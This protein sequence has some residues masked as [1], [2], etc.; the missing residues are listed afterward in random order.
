MDF[1]LKLNGIREHNVWDDVDKAYESDRGRIINSAAIR[2]LQQKTQ[3]FPLERNSAVRSR[4]THSLEVQQVGRF[5][6]RTIF[7][8]YSKLSS[9][10]QHL[11]GLGSFERKLETLVE[12]ACLMHDIGNPPFGHFGEGALTEWFT[13]HIEELCELSQSDLT[14]ELILDVSHFEG[15]AQG[16]RLISSLLDLNLTYSQA[17]GILKY[18]RCG[19]SKK[20]NKAAE[21]YYVKKK[22]GYYFSEKK[23]VED[24]CAK[25]RTRIGNR[26]LVSYI[27]EAA[28]DISYCIADLEDA[29]E[30]SILDQVQ[31]SKLIKDA[32]ENNLINENSNEELR[33]SERNDEIAEI[34]KKLEGLENKAKGD[35]ASF[36][37]QFRVAL[38]HPLVEHAATR[39]IENI[40][41]VYDGELY[42][43]LL[44]DDSPAHAL[45]EALK[46]VARDYVFCD[47]EVEERELQ[48]YVIIAGLLDCYKPLLAM[49]S[50][51]FLATYHQDKSSNLLCRRLIKK[52]PDKHI[53]AYRKASKHEPTL[54]FYYRCRLIQDYISGMTD[55]FAYDEYRMLTISD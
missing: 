23:Y 40:N 25:T 50:D 2:R 30:K 48:G 32:F 28:D 22:V 9:E 51:Q 49:T 1:T 38:I 39:F 13:Q 10:K 3:V 52:L 45:T 17:A 4:L 12:M 19:T 27:M 11:I 15:N 43:S 37:I 46:K 16:I 47:Q 26:H 41:K 24:L 36:L 21:D 20:P 55:Q 18:T 44:E 6:V 53:K 8:L 14:E 29:L 7:E 54:E 31:L 5:I 34:R 35:R 33:L 42:E